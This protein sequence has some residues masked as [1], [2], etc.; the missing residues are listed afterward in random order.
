MATT[1]ANDELANTDDLNQ[2]DRLARGQLPV[3]R[4][5]LSL[6]LRGETVS[7]IINDARIELAQRH[8]KTE[9]RSLTETA[10]LLGFSGLPT[11]SRWFQRQ[12]GSSATIW[13]KTETPIFTR[14]AP[15]VSR[16]AALRK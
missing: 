14:T 16:V 4:P 6:A 1:R 2:V 9:R 5:D 15:A 7:T 13:R 10:Q 8:I 11:F 3:G 12:F